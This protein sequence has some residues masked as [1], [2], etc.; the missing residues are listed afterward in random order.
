MGTFRAHWMGIISASTARG[1]AIKVHH[2]LQQGVQLPQSVCVFQSMNNQF[3]ENNA[4]LEAKHI[5]AV[6]INDN[7]PNTTFVVSW[8]IELDAE[9][10][11][12]MLK[13]TAR[14]WQDENS[15]AT[16]YQVQTL[17]GAH[18][19]INVADAPKLAVVQGGRI[20]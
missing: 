9:S 19:T 4:T 13:K 3:K 20:H 2:S 1:A 11:A 17:D 14:I 18:E 8:Y 15:R 12:D 7:D 16:V 6:P 10:L 5:A